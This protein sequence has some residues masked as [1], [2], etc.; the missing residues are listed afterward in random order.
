MYVAADK[1]SLFPR[2]LPSAFIYTMNVDAARFTA[3]GWDR[4]A[5]N[6]ARV[7]GMIFGVPAETLYAYDTCQFDKGVV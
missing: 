1:R 4:P 2:P 3:M 5:D 7:L 6:I